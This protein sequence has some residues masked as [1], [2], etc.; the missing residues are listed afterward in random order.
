MRRCTALQGSS[1]IFTQPRGVWDHGLRYSTEA[2]GAWTT[3][4]GPTR[5]RKPENGFEI[6][7]DAKTVDTAV[8]ELPLSPVMDPTFWEAKERFKKKK[9]KPGKPANPL[10]REF[11]KN[12]FA[13]ALA[14]PIRQEPLTQRRMPSFFLQDFK[15]I[16]HPETHNPWWVP[17]SLM[18]E[19]S[20]AAVE[21]EEPDGEADT[22]ENMVATGTDE[23]TPTEAS[24]AQLHEPGAAP[25]DGL[26]FGPSAYIL[27]R[28]DVLKSVNI[29]ESG[30]FQKHGRMYN[31]TSSRYRTL[32]GKAV[33]RQDMDAF[34]LGR[35]RQQI[36]DDIRYLSKLCTDEGSRY[37]IVKCFGWDDVK[38]KHRGA[39]LWFGDPVEAVA[40][41][42][43]E[44][45][46]FATFDLDVEGVAPKPTVVVHNMPMLLGD[47]H[48]QRVRKEAAV[49][50]DGSIFMLAGR[51]TTDLQ[52]RLWK[53][54]GYLSDFKG[55]T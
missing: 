21:Q 13:H 33:W 47:E 14:T 23:A 50:K 22:I 35:M 55:P 19:K 16:A 53:L 29:K 48:A 7:Q 4:T 37:Y 43:V 31:T 11:E 1:A 8:G 20:P 51:R 12:P 42:K 28:Q 54:Q 36:V 38:F 40:D 3:T 49:L 18:L 15:L 10:E 25:K 46:P 26:A 44:P 52:L 30:Y 34:V 6:D 9:L 41:Q 27:A 45:G 32:A 2:S 24:S 5:S 39:V 17:R